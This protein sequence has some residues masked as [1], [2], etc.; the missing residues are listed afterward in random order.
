MGAPVRRGRIAVVALTI[1]YAGFVGFTFA[2][3]LLGKPFIG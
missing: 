1:A 3:A 2:Q